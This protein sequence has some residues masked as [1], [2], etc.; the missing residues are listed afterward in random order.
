MPK[1]VFWGVAAFCMGKK[2]KR[3]FFPSVRGG[4]G[5]SLGDGEGKNE[6]QERKSGSSTGGI[7][8]GGDVGVGWSMEMMILLL[9]FFS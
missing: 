5:S 8:M 7:D 4:E 2:I 1:N 6:V 9:L 3:R